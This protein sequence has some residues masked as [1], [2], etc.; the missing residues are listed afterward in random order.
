MSCV[1]RLNDTDE[2]A[3]FKEAEKNIK[4]A[5]ENWQMAGS[6]DDEEEEVVM[7]EGSKSCTILWAAISVHNYHKVLGEISS[8]NLALTAEKML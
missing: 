4:Q 5:K 7:E 3:K 1:Q 2:E 6:D 8:S